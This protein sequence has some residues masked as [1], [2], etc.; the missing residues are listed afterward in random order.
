M[1]FG[2]RLG[3]RKIE[4]LS[5]THVRL[6]YGGGGG[7]GFVNRSPAPQRVLALGELGPKSRAAGALA[8]SFALRERETSGTQGTA[9]P[10]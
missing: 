3:S 4:M 9:P 6:L 2:K 7:G 1:T 10:T 5:N 8:P